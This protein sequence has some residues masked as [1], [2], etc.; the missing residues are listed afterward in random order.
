MLVLLVLAAGCQDDTSPGVDQ[1]IGELESTV[2]T[3]ESEVAGD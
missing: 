3:I 1:Q 2:A